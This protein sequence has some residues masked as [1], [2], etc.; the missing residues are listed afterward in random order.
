VTFTPTGGGSAESAS[1]ALTVG[2]DPSSPHNISLSGKGP[3]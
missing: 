3:S 2:S 1:M